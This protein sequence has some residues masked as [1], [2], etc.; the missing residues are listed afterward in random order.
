MLIASIQGALSDR[1]I[2]GLQA[3]VLDMIQQ[4][5]ATGVV[6]DVTAL[7]VIDSF[8][9]RTLCAISSAVQLRGARMVIVGIQ[10]EVALSMVLL[11]LDLSD[12]PTALDLDG[13]IE[14]LKRMPV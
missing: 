13:G 3:R 1:D 4:V 7:D 2:L 10:P 9:T 11:G 14:L 8:S 12:V 5:R 6:I